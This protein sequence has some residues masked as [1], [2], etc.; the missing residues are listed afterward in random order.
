MLHQDFRL[1]R[2]F[3]PCL[4]PKERC[5]AQRNSQSVTQNYSGGQ[6]QTDR[7]GWWNSEEKQHTRSSIRRK[8]EKWET[9]AVGK[10]P[11][12]VPDGWR[13][14]KFWSSRINDLHLLAEWVSRVWI[15]GCL[16]ANSCICSLQLFASFG[17]LITIINMQRETPQY[18]RVASVT[19][20][21]FRPRRKIW[22]DWE[23]AESVGAIRLLW[24]VTVVS[25]RNRHGTRWKI[26]QNGW[27]DHFYFFLYF[28]LLFN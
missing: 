21:Y 11:C 24:T 2:Q 18:P 4:Y 27:N 28:L 3:S 5:G 7:V 15:Q 19:A 6:A 26:S 22:Q 20:K 12:K 8:K 16:P 14:S 10:S 17:W 9:G 25:T 23:G 13:L 1:W